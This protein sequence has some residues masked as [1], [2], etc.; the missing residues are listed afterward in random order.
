MTKQ[1]ERK[2]PG[3]K[4]SVGPRVWVT[5]TQF[6][7]VHG[8]VHKVRSHHHERHSTRP[9]ISEYVPIAAKTR[10][11]A[12]HIEKNLPETFK[13]LNKIFAD[14]DLASEQVP[15]LFDIHTVFTDKLKQTELSEQNHKAIYEHCDQCLT[16]KI[17]GC[18]KENIAATINGAVVA[19][20]VEPVQM[21]M[22][23]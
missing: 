8:T 18:N 4:N 5:P 14:G 12:N 16:D 2:E 13:A 3:V 11:Y 22:G 23:S 10:D 15:L 6:E 19:D 7:R 20:Y 17:K 9:N 1:K 21:Q